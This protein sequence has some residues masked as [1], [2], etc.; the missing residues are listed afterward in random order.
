MKKLL[1]LI[2]FTLTLS[3][4]TSCWIEEKWENDLHQEPINYSWAIENNLLWEKELETEEVFEWEKQDIINLNKYYAL[5]E[6]NKLDELEKELKKED[7]DNPEIVKI[8]AKLLFAQNK[9]KDAL[10]LFLLANEM[11][12]SQNWDILLMIWIIYLEL[13]DNVSSKIYIDKA[14]ELNPDNEVILNY[15]K[16]ISEMNAK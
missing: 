9:T 2:I 10:D 16:L 1:F 6:D 15:K 13:N 8:K 4:I 3:I 5:L 12:E 7:I 14:Y 11:F